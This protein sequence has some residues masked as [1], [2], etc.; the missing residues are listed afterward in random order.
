MNIE[1]FTPEDADHFENI[2]SGG[3]MKKVTPSHIEQR[4]L[5][6]GY[7][8]KAVGGLMPTELGFKMFSKWQKSGQK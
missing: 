6:S 1:D 2:Y 7:A 8:R 3:L 4:F 5:Q